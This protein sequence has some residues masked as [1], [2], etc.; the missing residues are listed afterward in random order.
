MWE[1]TRDNA[2]EN[3]W[4]ELV[5]YFASMGVEEK[6][7]RLRTIANHSEPWQEGLAESCVK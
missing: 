3:K 6:Q 1:V 4:K 5:E 7:H 2:G